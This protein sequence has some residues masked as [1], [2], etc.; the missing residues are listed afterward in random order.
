MGAI[1]TSN[2]THRGKVGA[3]DVTV[4]RHGPSGAFSAFLLLARIVLAGIAG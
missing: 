4:A 2:A 1:R 3:P